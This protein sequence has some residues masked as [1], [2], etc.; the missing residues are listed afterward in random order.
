MIFVNFPDDV[1]NVGDDQGLD[2]N[3]FGSCLSGEGSS[4]HVASVSTDKS[5]DEGDSI[6]MNANAVPRAP[7]GI[8]VEPVNE[9]SIPPATLYSCGCQ[10]TSPGDAEGTKDIHQRRGYTTYAP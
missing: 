10:D 3:F 8:T 4:H 7:L 5:D 6:L 1:L 9:V 2:V